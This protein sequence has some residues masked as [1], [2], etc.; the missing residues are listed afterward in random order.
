MAFKKVVNCSDRKS[1]K[2]LGDYM[3]KAGR[4]KRE[5]YV[6]RMDLLFVV[7]NYVSTDNVDG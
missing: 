4:L 5:R 6:E 3:L 7:D 2:P 1:R